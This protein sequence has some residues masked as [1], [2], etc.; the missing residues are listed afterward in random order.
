MVCGRCGASVRTVIER[1]MGYLVERA[2]CTTGHSRDLGLVM[3]P[4]VE[5][6]PL[7][8]PR[9]YVRPHEL[10]LAMRTC[11][12]GVVFAP[13]RKDH[14]YHTQGCANASRDRRRVKV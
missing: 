12:C 13:K 9:A 5:A 11:P 7:P 14:R 1:C 3:E 2:V 4:E 10:R 6:R 8:P